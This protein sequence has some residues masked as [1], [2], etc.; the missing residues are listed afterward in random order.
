VAVEDK[1]F[2]THSG[3]DLLT[4]LRIIKNVFYFGK[5]TGGSTLTQQ[6]TR[7]VLLT[8]EEVTYMKD[9]RK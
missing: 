9:K 3:I 7:N 6:L 5:V 1:S 2:Y 8:T 4:P